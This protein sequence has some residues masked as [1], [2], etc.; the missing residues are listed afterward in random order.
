MIRSAVIFGD[1]SGMPTTWPGAISVT[2]IV[3]AAAFCFAAW[4]RWGHRGD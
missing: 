2:I 3:I 1:G 4:L